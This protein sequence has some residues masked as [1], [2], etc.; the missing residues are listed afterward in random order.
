MEE[1]I[2][3]A[4]FSG[5]SPAMSMLGFAHLMHSVQRNEKRAGADRYIPHFQQLCCLWD[6]SGIR[7][8][9]QLLTIAHFHGLALC[10][11]RAV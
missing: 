6:S 4:A 10:S 11:E 8:A 7:C 5:P 3:A 2:L 1:A 9:S